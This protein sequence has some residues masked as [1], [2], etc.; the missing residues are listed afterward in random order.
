MS[1]LDKLEI[2]PNWEKTEYLDIKRG[3][4][5]GIKDHP[6]NLLT[7]DK[8]GYYVF[9]NIDD[10][11]LCAVAPEMLEYI[12]NHIISVDD[13]FEIKGT[14]LCDDAVSLVEKATGYNWEDLKELIT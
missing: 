11:N 9:E 6:Q 14:P 4:C 1:I 2:T 12:I 7:S 5:G 3:I 10:R 13:I 8:D